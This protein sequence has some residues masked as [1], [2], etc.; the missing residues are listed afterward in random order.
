MENVFDTLE[1]QV[2]YD[3]A[4]HFNIHPS[5]LPLVSNT[6]DDNFIYLLHIT[7]F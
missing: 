7:K 2:E 1:R 3:L 4:S 5:N 6:N